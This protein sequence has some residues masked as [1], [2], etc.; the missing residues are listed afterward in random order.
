MSDLTE[1]T[2]HIRAPRSATPRRPAP[3]PSPR[4]TRARL[5]PT[6]FP[7]GAGHVT[8]RV[9]GFDERVQDVHGL[10]VDL[11]GRLDAVLSLDAGRRVSV[12]SRG[13]QPLGYLPTSWARVVEKELRRYEVRGLEAVARSTLSGAKGD[14]TLCVLL[15]WPR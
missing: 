15:A 10:S 11:L 2:T 6:P 7:S 1:L 4:R 12:A 13:G 8:V 3:A 14:R 5:L 9:V